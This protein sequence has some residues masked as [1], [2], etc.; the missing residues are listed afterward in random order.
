MVERALREGGG[1]PWHVARLTVELVRPV[2]LE[3]LRVEAAVVRPGR[4]VQLVEASLTVA[5]SGQEVLKAR[6]LAVRLVGLPLPAGLPLADEPAPAPPHEAV[7]RV[8]SFGA[9][10]DEAFHLHGAE[11]RFVD[12]G[13]D[14]PGPC[15]VWIRLRVPVVA[16][17]EPSGLQRVAAAADFGNGVSRV[18]PD[19]WLFINPDLTVHLA[20]PAEGPWVCLR[21]ATWP[22]PQGVGLAESALWDE[23]GRL[24]RSCQSLLLDHR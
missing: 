11:H 15:T 16:G 13:W 2:P 18:L 1:G 23:R 8:S 20:R 10:V 24:G 5:S 14:V 22:S 12:G 21:S 3:P 6:A 4:K 9:A 17:E 7:P 19:T